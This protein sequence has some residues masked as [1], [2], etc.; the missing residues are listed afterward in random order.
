MSLRVDDLKND[1]PDD[2]ILT[3]VRLH[4][5][6]ASGIES[7][8]IAIESD[9]GSEY[10]SVLESKPMNGLTDDHYTDWAIIRAVDHV[11]FTYPNATGVTWGLEMVYTRSSEIYGA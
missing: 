9:E 10:N 11:I 4:L 7:F 6:G 3:E 8:S 5:S 2:I 1:S